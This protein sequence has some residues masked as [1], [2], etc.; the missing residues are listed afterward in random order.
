MIAVGARCLQASHERL[1][2]SVYYHKVVFDLEVALTH[3][4]AEIESTFIR[5]P[6]CENRLTITI[7]TATHINA[8]AATTPAMIASARNGSLH[9]PGVLA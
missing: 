3:G 2:A 1:L 4:N 8:L 7:P 9:S 6:M 5:H